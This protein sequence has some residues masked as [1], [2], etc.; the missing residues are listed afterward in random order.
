MSM[1]IKVIMTKCRELRL[2]ISG[3]T[4]TTL[5]L[6]RS[7]WNERPNLEY[8]NFFQKHPDLDE[9]ELYVR[10]V[11]GKKAEKV[12]ID[13]CTGISNEFSGMKL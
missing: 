6:F 2:M 3:E 10:A 9:P 7:R 13:L 11:K 1:S 8:A 5:Q 12:F 4:H